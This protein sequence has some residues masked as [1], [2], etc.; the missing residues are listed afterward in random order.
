MAELATISRPYAE[1]AFAV[2]REDKAPESLKSWTL[3]LEQAAEV[4]KNPDAQKAFMLPGITI[5][6]SI[7]LIAS[8]AG[9]PNPEQESLLK[10]LAQNERL[11]LLPEIYHQFSELVSSAAHELSACVESAFEL[12]QAQSASISQLLKSKYGSDIKL[13]VTVNPELIGGVR[14]SVGDEVIDAS[15]REKLSKMTAALLN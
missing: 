14:I 12:T 6:Q 9:K 7:E 11:S 13:S 1:A 3:F 2:A 8:V 4:A 5:T 10:M 15:V